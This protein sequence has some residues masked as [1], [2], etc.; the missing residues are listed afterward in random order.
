MSYKIY[1]TKTSKRDIT[2][3]EI[4]L[5]ENF[6]ETVSNNTLDELFDTIFSLSE[7][8]LKGKSSS[9]LSIHLSR[10]R[11]LPLKQNIVF[12]R[13]DEDTSSLFVLRILSTKEDFVAKLIKA[14]TLTEEDS[15]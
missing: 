15:L 6:S 8:P 3:L 10:Y 7:F 12:Y 13:I 4:Q 1:F 5:L 9:E 14:Y 11:Y 2:N